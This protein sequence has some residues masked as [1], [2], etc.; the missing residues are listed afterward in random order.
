MRLG[1]T[2]VTGTLDLTFTT[3]GT[4][5]QNNQTVVK[6][7]DLSKPDVGSYRTSNAPAT[8]DSGREVVFT[9]SATGTTR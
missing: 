4:H 1:T 2:T 9:V 6:V 5:S 8:S 7:H 3:C